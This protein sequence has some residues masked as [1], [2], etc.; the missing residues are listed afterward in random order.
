MRRKTRKL[1]ICWLFIWFYSFTLLCDC[2][3][4]FYAF[5]LME[6]SIWII[7]HVLE[8][9]AAWWQNYSGKYL[10]PCQASAWRWNGLWESTITLMIFCLLAKRIQKAH[11]SECRE[12]KQQAISLPE[13]P[14]LPF[15]PVLCTVGLFFWPLYEDTCAATLP[16]FPAVWHLPFGCWW[17]LKVWFHGMRCSIIE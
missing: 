9:S 6:H 16:W 14:L 1:K 12:N 8:S 7:H 15:Q 17:I 5:L 11:F 10:D 4:F 2:L 3:L 13:M